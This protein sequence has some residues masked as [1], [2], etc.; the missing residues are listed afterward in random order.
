MYSFINTCTGG[1]GS[2][3]EEDVAPPAELPAELGRW[4]GDWL[5]LRRACTDN[6]G[7][8]HSVDSLPLTTVCED[9]LLIFSPHKASRINLDTGFEVSRT[10]QR[11]KQE[12]VGSRKRKTSVGDHL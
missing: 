10:A 11:L 4:R 1:T 2:M 12:C 6:D 5:V 8:G 9:K 7:S 3:E